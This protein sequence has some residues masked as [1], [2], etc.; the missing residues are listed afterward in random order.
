MAS[1]G[2]RGGD[3]IE[4]AIEKPVAGGRMI[5]RHNGQ[6][7]LVGGGVPGERVRA[8][9]E[10]ADRRLAL[11]QAIEILDPSPDRRPAFADPLCGGC[12]FSHLAYPR[13]LDLKREI[14]V[15]ALA[16][17]GHIAHD[18]PVAINGSAEFEYRLRARLHVANGRVGFFK[19]GTH[20]LCDAA[21][22]RQLRDAALDSVKRAAEYAAGA[23][24][25]VS[26]IE[27]TENVPGTEIAL[28]LDVEDGDRLAGA[29]LPELTRAAEVNGCVVRDLKGR[30][31][32]SGEL[33][34]GDP[35]T[36]L[37]MERG[38]RGELRRQ[39]E[40]FFQANRFLVPTLVAQ[41]VDAVPADGPVLDL[42]AGVGLFSVTL[43][44]S[45][46]DDITAVEGD[47]TSGAD[48]RRNAG[49][50]GAS[51][52]L[53]LESVESHLRSIDRPPRAATV[54]VDPPRTGMSSE[55]LTML[56]A[57]GAG[58]IIY[59][60]CDPPTL[61]RDARKLLDARYTLAGLEAFDLFPNTPHV[62]CVAVFER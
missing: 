34:V 20:T 40:S 59:V 57:L 42:Y 6:V 19:E 61:A 45:G 62:E 2:L 18:R 36:V 29:G 30:R 39:P 28:A 7:V 58:R 8:R 11:A 16:R 35:I 4:V 55:A 15:D 10:K 26:S 27:F 52:T 53:A 24:V 49:L 13:Q 48:L 44:A 5:A 1:P 47:R 43:A 21:S 12:V 25:R 33:T 50:F 31:R 60:S 38:T 9:I 41:V 37:S 56:T 14:V 17:I 54:I 46:R 51:L 3:E 23:G 32:V 22:T